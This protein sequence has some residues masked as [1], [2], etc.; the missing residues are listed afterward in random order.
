MDSQLGNIL[1]II[2]NVSVRIDSE[3]LD[4]TPVDNNTSV[5][6]ALCGRLSKLYSPIEPSLLPAGKLRTPLRNDFLVSVLIL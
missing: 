1:N 6:V 2:R 5:L 4:T 3:R